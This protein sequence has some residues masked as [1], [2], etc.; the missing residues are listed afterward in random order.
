MP[1]RT[2]KKQRK[3]KELDKSRAELPVSDLVPALSKSDHA[4]TFIVVFLD[5][6][7]QRDAFDRV[8]Q[9]LNRD[10]VGIDEV[11]RAALDVLNPI[12]TLRGL[13][14][15]AHKSVGRDYYQSGKVPM[16][17]WGSMGFADTVVLWL[18][19]SASN[20]KIRELGHIL[21]CLTHTKR[22]CVRNRIL[23]RGGVDIGPAQRVF[24]GQIYGP[25][26]FSAYKLAERQASVPRI[27]VGSA[28]TGLLAHAKQSGHSA[29]VTLVEQMLA[30]DTRDGLTILDYL[31]VRMVPLDPQTLSDIKAQPS[32]WLDLEAARNR[33]L[34]PGADPK[35]SKEYLKRAEKYKYVADYVRRKI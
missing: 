33:S 34:A 25:A 13:L 15:A 20:L 29:R 21:A 7:G 32:D 22:E 1:G 28:V 6:L 3:K 24:G 16:P 19:I 5:V 17:R 11:N 27:L 9:A 18:P 26:Y 4:G 8:E 10:E 2:T 23:L 30:Q 12:A 31:D 14:N 35:M